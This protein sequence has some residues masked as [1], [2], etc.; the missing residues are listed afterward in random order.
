MSGIYNATAPWPTTN[1]HFTET[2]GKVLNQPA[3]L[4]VPGFLL[5]WLYGEA[6]ETL[7][8][9]KRVVSERLEKEGF[10]FEFPTIEKAL[11]QAYK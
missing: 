3:Y 2:L 7:I 11:M 10:V 9:G 8:H 1:Y 6:A 4:T 5:R